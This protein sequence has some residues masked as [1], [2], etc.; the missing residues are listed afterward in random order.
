MIF[1]VRLI[2]ILS[3]SQKARTIFAAIA[4]ISKSR[5]CVWNQKMILSQ[6]QT[7]SFA[8]SNFK[9]TQMDQLEEVEDIKENDLNLLLKHLNRLG[10]IGGRDL[11]VR[12]KPDLSSFVDSWSAG[13]VGHLPQTPMAHRL[14]DREWMTES[15]FKYLNHDTW[16]STISLAKLLSQINKRD[17]RNWRPTEPKREYHCWFNLKQKLVLKFLVVLRI[18]F[19]FIAEKLVS[20]LSDDHSTIPKAIG[21]LEISEFTYQ[22]VAINKKA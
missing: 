7:R 13:V 5:I 4:I 2:F 1:L 22:D 6:E 18:H 12:S 14:W 3:V 17:T 19:R 9:T 10:K 8:R 15:T 11:T 16:T 20:R 21:K